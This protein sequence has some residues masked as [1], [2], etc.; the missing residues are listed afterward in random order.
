MTETTTT[1][2]LIETIAGE[3]AGI[4]VEKPTIP[5]W[6]VLA[7]MQD[8]H[9]GSVLIKSDARLPESLHFEAKQLGAWKVLTEANGF[10]VE[11]KLSEVGWQFFFMVP[12]VRIGRLAYDRKKG[13]RRALKKLVSAVETQNYNALEI[14]EI[15]TRSFLGLSYV[16][17]VAHP[18]HVKNS[19]FLR[20]P[21]PNHVPRNVWHFKGLL[22][23][24]SEVGLMRK[25]V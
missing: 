14:V 15:N 7:T 13:L 12:E 25:G 10:E 20:D 24:R 19:P 5:T 16:E 1:L 2:D 3:N 18:R 4:A 23:R 9:A 6:L 11:R 17:V 8:I 22:R 21:D